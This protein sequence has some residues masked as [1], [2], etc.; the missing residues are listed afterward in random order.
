MKDINIK[1]QIMENDLWIDHS[2]I[3]TW[4]PKYDEIAND[5]AEYR[6]LVALT[7]MEIREK[8][9]ISRQTFIG[10][11][12]WKSPR[13][14][15]IVRLNEFSVY[16]KGI[17]AAYSAEENEKLKTLIQLR[18][19]GTPVGSTILH[20]I[21]PNSFPIID[22]RTAE[23]L[24]YARR[25]KSKSTDFSNYISFR[26]EMLKI[27]K[28]NPSFTLREI[29]RALFAY[30]K[31]HLAPQSP[32]TGQKKKNCDRS[33]N[34][35]GQMEGFHEF[36]A[37]LTKDVGCYYDHTSKAPVYSLKKYDSD[38]Q[39]KM[40]VFGWVN[41]LKRSNGFRIDT[42]WYLADKAGVAHL[43]DATK[44]GMHFISKKYDPEGKGTGISIFVRN[45]SNGEDYQKAV[46]ALKA[47]MSKK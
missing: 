32:K 26:L 36:N 16:E 17:S 9:T 38:E 3:T 34:L 5:E 46:Q 14:K 30:H 23:T 2:F 47:I 31:I 45:S 6:N 18:G 4:H 41:E 27:A 44:D 33:I 7:N 10:I 24:C 40:G 29:D 22:I 11:L 1:G 42:Y 21:Y 28:E 15:G 12:N 19:I 20:F 43:A 13:V 37:R 25:I 39:G 35:E 8:C